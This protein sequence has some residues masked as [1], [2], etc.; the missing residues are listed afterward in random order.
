LRDPQEVPDEGY[1]G[2]S[3]SAIALP[4]HNIAHGRSIDGPLNVL[5][6]GRHA[7]ILNRSDHRWCQFTLDSQDELLVAGLG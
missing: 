6:P 2:E 4:V 1:S 3:N 5:V 7:D